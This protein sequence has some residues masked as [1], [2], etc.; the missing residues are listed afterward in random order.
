MDLAV[1]VS[2]LPHKEVIKQRVAMVMAAMGI[3]TG[4]MAGMGTQ[5]LGPNG[6]PMPVGQAGPLNQQAQLSGPR[7]PTRGQQRAAQRPRAGG[8]PA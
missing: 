5:M 2:S 8:V 4:D 3:P 1:D 6:Q 7:Q